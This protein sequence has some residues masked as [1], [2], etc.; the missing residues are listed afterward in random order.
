MVRRRLFQKLIIR[1][2]ERQMKKL[3][4]GI[5]F[6]GGLFGLLGFEATYAAE[7]LRIGVSASL[8]GPTVS[9]GQP[10][11]QTVLTHAK[12]YNA[13]GGVKIGNTTY[14]LEIVAADDKYQAETGAA[15]INNLI[16]KEKVDYILI[17]GPST[18]VALAGG[19]ICEKNKVLFICNGTSGPGLDAK[20]T[21]VFRAILT[22]FSRG[23]GLVLWL[24]ENKPEIK[25]VAF[26]SPDTEGG[27]KDTENFK[28]MM[29]IYT[30][31]K[32]VAGEYFEAS[33][34][35]YFSVLSKVLKEKP[36]I[37]FTDTASPGDL[38]LLAKQGREL[39]YKGP[40]LEFALMDL[41]VHCKIAG[42]QACDDLYHPGYSLDTT[43]ELRKLNDA[44]K[45]TYGEYNAMTISHCDF[46]SILIQGMQRAG[47]I[48]KYKVKEALA[49]GTKPGIFNSMLGPG[50]RFYEEKATAIGAPRQWIAPISIARSRNGENEI[51]AQYPVDSIVEKMAG[52][53]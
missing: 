31:W 29:E 26:T 22:N 30:N 13:A 34:K 7:T 47:T 48:D 46:L 14:K 21:W 42:K 45:A 5:G 37:I 38:G 23:L 12:L 51:I 41:G 9:W 10:A 6:L 17:G 3:L 11:Y 52:W 43:P 33:S 1:K 24:S 25:K 53:K 27:H 49:N 4:I 16:F 8:S 2:G 40:F 15:A 19:P 50:A 18:L 44:Y 32:L 28:K 20:L 35:D 36:D 39:G